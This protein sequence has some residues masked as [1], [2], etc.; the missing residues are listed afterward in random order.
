MFCE[1]LLKQAQLCHSVFPAA[2]WPCFNDGR[3]PLAERQ[4]AVQPHVVVI[5]VIDVAMV[6][7]VVVVVEPSLS[8]LGFPPLP[9]LVRWRCHSDE[10]QRSR[11]VLQ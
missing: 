10:T 7:V 9:F 1:L 8:S 4:A 11:V 6:V 2:G 3:S 5:V